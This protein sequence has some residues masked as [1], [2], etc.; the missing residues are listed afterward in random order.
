[1]LHWCKNSSIFQFL[2]AVLL[3]KHVRNS[4][5]NAQVTRALLCFHVYGKDLICFKHLGFSDISV[6]CN[7]IFL[8]P[9][10]FAY[11]STA[12]QCLLLLLPGG[13]HFRKHVLSRSR[14]KNNVWS[15]ALSISFGWCSLR[16]D[17]ST[18]VFQAPTDGSVAKPCMF[19]ESFMPSI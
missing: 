7:G 19:S 15:S 18:P 8:D 5:N 11:T 13:F 1:M 9:S 4:T 16:R 10:I 3:S 6:S 17:R 2:A 12:I 14:L